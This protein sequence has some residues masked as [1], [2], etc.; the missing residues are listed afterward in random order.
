MK[1]A[2]IWTCK[3]VDLLQRNYKTMNVEDLAKL[4]K[5]TP[6]AV[7]QKM[8]KLGLKKGWAQVEWTPQ[9][10]KLLRDFFPTMFNEAL[11]KW[12]GVSPRT[13]IRK[14]RKLGLEKQEGFLEKRRDDIQRKAGEARKARGDVGGTWFK[15]GVHS[16]PAGEFKKGHVETPETKAKRS[17]ALK[18]TWAHKKKMKRLGLS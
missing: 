16:N 11:A 6:K 15:K 17:A 4:V 18:A 12:I 1:R 3:Q 13:L 7:Q 8:H 5:R 9:M 2:D 10:L 14:A